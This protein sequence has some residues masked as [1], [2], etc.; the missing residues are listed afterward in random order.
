MLIATSAFFACMH[1]SPVVNSWLVYFAVGMIFGIAYLKGG[2]VCSSLAHF[3]Y[4]MFA[5]LMSVNLTH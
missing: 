5:V 1:V 3:S 2:F 4:N